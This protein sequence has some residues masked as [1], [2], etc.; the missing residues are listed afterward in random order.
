MNNYYFTYLMQKQ[1][2]QDFNKLI[3]N[4]LTERKF[5]KIKEF[6]LND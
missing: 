2:K 3:S 4:I 1:G 5:E 6:N